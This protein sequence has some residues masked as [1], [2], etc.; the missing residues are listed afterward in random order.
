[1][2]GLIGH[3]QNTNEKVLDGGAYLNLGGS[4]CGLSLEEVPELVCWVRSRIC[5]G[6]FEIKT[7]T[8]SALGRFPSL[9][10]DGV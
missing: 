7:H 10:V 8:D 2:F 6:L 9:V 4:L 3:S 1:M 5:K